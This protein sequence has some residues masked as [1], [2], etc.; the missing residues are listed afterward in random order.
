MKYL[1]LFSGIEA[2][3]AAWRPLG[4]ECCAVA[5]VEPFP[6]AVL[7]H[8]YPDVPN[9]G[10]IT[11]ITL[12]QI[13]ALGKIDLVVGGFPCQDVSVAGKRAGLKNDDGTATRSGLFFDAMRIVERANPRWTVIENVP[14]LFS[15]NGGADFAAVVG[16]MAGCE[17]DV[18]ADGWRSSGV[19]VGPL[20]LVEWTVL[21]AQYHGLAQRRRRVFL[22]RDSGNWDDRPPLFL[23]PYRLQGHPAPCREAGQEVTGTIS[24]RTQGGGGLGTDFDLDGELIPCPDI[25]P[26]AMSSKWSKGSKGSSGP[27]GDEVANLVAHSLRAEGFDSSEDGTGCGT[28]L[29]PVVFNLR[30][31]EDGA[32]PEVD[33]DGIASLRAASGGSSRSYVAT[34]V[35]GTQDPCT[36]D[37]VAFALGRNNGQENAV[38]FHENQRAEITTNDTAGT[39]KCNGGKPGQG[40]PAIQHG[41]SVR[42]LT[43]VECS[44][45]QGFED[46]YLNILFRKKPAKDG[47]KYKSLGNSFA[48]TVI[49]W[50]GGRI[51]S[52]EEYSA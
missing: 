16:T 12:E 33:E 50:I 7:A 48:T 25:V 20:G 10:D 35:H 47:P 46:D 1:S 37:H 17:F 39:L 42:R 15:S 18:P 43:P 40:Y 22:V 38:A 4:W 28:P 49:Q 29:V 27:A 5:E 6:C 3:S 32:Q 23:E 36:D 13:T 51:K 21:D 24:A 34:V 11:K 9:L 44:R 8:H 19:A 45:L 26:Q 52:A 14:G 2:A 31:R 41:M 30:G